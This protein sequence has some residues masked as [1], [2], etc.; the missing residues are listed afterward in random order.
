MLRK[1]R[2]GKKKFG[3]VLKDGIN[4]DAASA[5]QHHEHHIDVYIVRVLGEALPC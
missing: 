3:E 1:E 4:S 5:P 2:K